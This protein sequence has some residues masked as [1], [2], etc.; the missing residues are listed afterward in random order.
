MIRA[1]FLLVA[2][3]ALWQFALPLPG[4][5]GEPGDSLKSGSSALIR[6]FLGTVGP[7]GIGL[8]MS[9]GDEE[10]GATLA[11]ALLM[12]GGVLVGPSLGHFYAERPGRALVGIGIRVLGGAGMIGGFAIAWESD[13]WNE[14]DSTAGEA[15]FLAGAAVTAASAIVD[16][17]T[18]PQSARRHNEKIGR[19]RVSLAPAAVGHARAPGLRLD[20]TF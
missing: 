16:I 17:A 18:A 15:L 6:S 20:V 9:A 7:V 11:S 2:A 4:R 14:S 3:V 12:S 13:W 19:A 8:A 1:R 10:D 5:A